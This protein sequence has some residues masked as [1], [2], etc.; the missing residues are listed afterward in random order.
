MT[1]TYLTPSIQPENGSLF[2]PVIIV[3]RMMINGTVS[4]WFTT[5]ISSIAFV[6]TYVFG[7]P[8]KFTLIL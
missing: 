1:M 4:F 7:Q 5:S 3:G 6:N 8:Y 2:V